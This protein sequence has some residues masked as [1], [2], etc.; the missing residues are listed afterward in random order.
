MPWNK[1]IERI[2]HKLLFEL[3]VY[4]EQH[5]SDRI[6]VNELAD[7][8]GMSSATFHRYFKKVSGESPIQYIKGSRLSR[9][10][11]RIYGVPSVFKKHYSICPYS[12]QKI[13]VQGELDVMCKPPLLWLSPLLKWLGQIPSYNES[14]VSVTVYFEND[15]NSKAFNFRRIFN[16][17]NEKS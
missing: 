6:L 3:M 17:R 7:Q 2:I 8:C 4:I 1:D 15:V 12:E 13:T 9:E 14:N 10:F 5:L 11:K 16:V